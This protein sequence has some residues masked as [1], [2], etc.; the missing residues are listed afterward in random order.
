MEYFCP[1]IHTET[2]DELF[3]GLINA[4]YISPN[5]AALEN[6]ISP[7][8]S[9]KEAIRVVSGWAGLARVGS[10]SGAPAGVRVGNRAI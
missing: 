5:F 6:T 7:L 2:Y 3:M 8:K 1:S 9:E 4:Y 10:R